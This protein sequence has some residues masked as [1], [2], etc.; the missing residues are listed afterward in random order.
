LLEANRLILADLDRRVAS[1]DEREAKARSVLDDCA[2]ERRQLEVERDAILTADRLYRR[3]FIPDDTAP[4]TSVT[5][6]GLGATSAS[7]LVKPR[8]RIG[9]Q[10][11]RILAHLRLWNKAVVVEEI[12]AATGLSIKRIH[13]QLRVD[14]PNGIIGEV[15]GRYCLKCAGWDL[16]ERFEH[17]K[18]SKGEPLPLLHGP[19]DDDE[20]DTEGAGLAATMEEEMADGPR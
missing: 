17:Y 20:G 13:D 19:I 16:L 8:A 10:R 11:Y 12:A 6:V 14:M 1:V 5:S 3:R 15:E 4:E 9:P 2:A 18:R 7:A